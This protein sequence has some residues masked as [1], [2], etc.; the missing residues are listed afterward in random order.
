MGNRRHKFQNCTTEN[1]DSESSMKIFSSKQIMKKPVP[2]YWLLKKICWPIEHLEK[3][4]CV[5]IAYYIKLMYTK[6]II[7]NALCINRYYYYIAIRYHNTYPI[8]VST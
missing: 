8:E 3:V 1:S 4:L 2:S 7:I 6:E 5:F